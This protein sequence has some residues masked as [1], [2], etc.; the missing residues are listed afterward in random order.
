MRPSSGIEGR[1]R[2]RLLRLAGAVVLAVAL[3]VALAVWL[4]PSRAPQ[5]APEA[6]AAVKPAADRSIELSASQI[7]SQGIASAAVVAATQLP[8]PGLPA[9]ATAPLEASARV[10]VPY[11]G[12]VTRILV[13]EGGSVR[14]GQ[15]L[16]RL[17]SRDLLMAQADLARARSEA[18]AAS[19]QAR[20]DAALLAEGIIAASRNEQSQARASAAEGARRQAE[21]A[22]S[23]LRAVA[24]GQPGEYELLAPISGQVLR[25]LVA[26]GQA[27]AALDEA[28]V[29]AEPGPLDV[30]FTA[31]VRVRAALAPGL[32]VRLPDGTSARVVAVG[33]DTDPASQSLR[34]RARVAGM[35]AGADY[36]A[37]QQFS[38]TLL[39]PAPAGTLAVP[40]AA[41]LPSGQGQ[42]LYRQDGR[43]IRAVPVQEVLGGDE[44]TSIVRAAGLSPGAQVVTRGTALLKSLIP[45]E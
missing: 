45:A 16:A 38:V 4:W 40:T 42:V 20:R 8:L 11:A 24:D 36:A 9:Q 15:P 22:L 17:R 26:P 34:V 29:V 12:V 5:T 23:Q 1:V 44:V 18:L 32:E 25:R 2:R 3:A 31:P 39:L 13:D 19:Q 41:L 37:G 43:R 27:L 33:A 21:G 14:R 10:V 35:K 28:F 7:R 30:T 6:A